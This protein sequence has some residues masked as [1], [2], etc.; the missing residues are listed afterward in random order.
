MTGVQFNID[1]DDTKAR[2]VL[3]RLAAR[4]ENLT[5]LMEEIGSFLELITRRRFEDGVDPEG[6][7]WTPHAPSTVR[8]RGPNAKILV[9][10]ARLLQSITSQASPDEVVVGTN[11][12]YGGIHQFGGPLPHFTMPARPFLGVNADDTEEIINITTEYIRGAVQ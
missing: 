6:R 4:G 8:R 3:G 12:V 10:T 7:P 9:D 5:P 2:Q 1:L 11:L